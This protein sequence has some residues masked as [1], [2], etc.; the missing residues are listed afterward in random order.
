MYSQIKYLNCY[1][2][3]TLQ[4]HYTHVKKNSNIVGKKFDYFCILNHNANNYEN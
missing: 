4:S 3:V 1:A 2:V